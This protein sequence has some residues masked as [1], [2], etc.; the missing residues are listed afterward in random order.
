MH[1]LTDLI[2]GRP[3]VVLLHGKSVAIL[4]E[5]ISSLHG[6][7]ICYISLNNF[8]PVVRRILKPADLALDVVYCSS[9]LELPRRID[10][11]RRHLDERETNLLITT[12]EAI[13]CLDRPLNF[14][15][16]YFIQTLAIDKPSRLAHG[17]MPPSLFPLIHA[18]IL[19]RATTVVMFGADG[20]EDERARTQQKSYYDTEMFANSDRP[21]EVT[22]DTQ[23]INRYFG[24]W[25]SAVQRN[26][27][28]EIGLYNCSPETCITAIPEITWARAVELLGGTHECNSSGDEQLGNRGTG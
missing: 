4:E 2:A 1:R 18:L 24:G 16:T 22:R 28:H 14:L 9:E 25:R 21:T 5:K 6:T 12:S 26:H 10:D 20:S 13:D 7:D 3:V 15:R 11:V 17:H 23:S 27:G 19:A 8:S